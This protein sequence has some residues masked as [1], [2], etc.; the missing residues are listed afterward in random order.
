MSETAID[1]PRILLAPMEGVMEF[2][3]R[4]MLTRIGGY[5]RCVTE[6]VRVSSTVLPPKVFFRLCPELKQG[7]TTAAGTPVYVQ[8]LG[9]DPAL[10]AA[11]AKVVTTLGV[12]GIDLNFGCPAKTVNKSRGGATLLKTPSAVYE[13]CAAVRDATPHTIPVTAKIRL[14]FESDIDF[15]EIASQALKSG[16]TELT[17]HARTKA[18]AYRP[19]AHWQRLR[20]ITNPRSVPIIANGEIWTPSDLFDCRDQSGCNAFMLARGALCRPDLARAIKAHCDGLAIE[21]MDWLEITELLLHFFEANGALYQRKYAINPLKQWLVYLQYCYP[22][23][24]ALFA[25]VKRIR[26]P[27]AMRTAL[28]GA[29]DPLA[30]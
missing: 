9:S 21:P 11:N 2:A 13:I 26:D 22:Q 27:D 1:S 14:G 5:E 15:E 8:L 28:L 3:M 24:A 18:Q 20:D 12:S 30:A 19:P 17:V 4:D 7:G 25:Q 29:T 23:A 16:I 10:M 6:F